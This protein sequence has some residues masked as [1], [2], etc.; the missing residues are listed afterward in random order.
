[1]KKQKSFFSNAG[2]RNKDY[3]EK[4]YTQKSS[5]KVQDKITS[6]DIREQVEKYSHLSQ[7]E[8]MM[9]MFRTAGES[10][11]NG[12]LDNATLDEFLV[13]ASP[14]LTPDQLSKMKSLI[15]QLKV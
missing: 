9:E 4:I 11:A 2:N 13:Q 7:E 10:R 6:D 1:M 14:M 5:S 15:D 8:L 12:Q 3:K